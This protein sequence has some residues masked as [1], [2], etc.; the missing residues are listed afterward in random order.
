MNS[1]AYAC[2]ALVVTA[3]AASTSTT[4]RA[5]I[6]AM[7]LSEQPNYSWLSLIDERS[8]SYEIE[9]KVTPAGITWIRMPMI[10]TIARHIGREAD[11]QL[12]VFFNA[13]R[14]GV[15]RVGGD[16]R[17]PGE[18]ALYRERESHDRSR[19]MVRGSAAGR[20]GVAGGQS[21]G[22]AAPFFED[23]RGKQTARALPFGVT[24]PHEELA[25]LVG[26]HVN[27]DASDDAVTGTLTELGAA[28]LLVREGEADVEVL[29]SAGSFRIWLNRGVVIKYQL[30][31][32]GHLL[33]GGRRKMHT[34]LR[35][36]TLLKDVGATR[37]H[38]PD[39]AQEKLASAAW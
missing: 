36:T 17:L 28:L 34:Q 13:H 2:A 14:V 20:F 35:T 25:V 22:A 27:L 31:L 23:R 8:R 19:P 7:K 15:I 26:S 21:V 1:L 39:E 6:A 9:G 33:V 11:T 18:I 16:W 4:D 37:V 38:V 30:K 29:Q 3:A 32:E 24:Y 5:I 10:Q 12:E